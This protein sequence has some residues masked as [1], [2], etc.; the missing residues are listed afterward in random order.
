MYPE[1][2]R[3]LGPAPP[4]GS[5]PNA[6]RNPNFS[7]TFIKGLPFSL[8]PLQPSRRRRTKSIPGP[9]EASPFAV[10]ERLEIFQG[11]TQTQAQHT[12]SHR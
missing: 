1:L 5:R 3:S 10:A 7:Q 6:P 11:E 2:N 12:T 4:R 8:P 9:E